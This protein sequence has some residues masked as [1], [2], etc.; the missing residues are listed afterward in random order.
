MLLL[1]V[2]ATA[3]LVGVMRGGRLG[4]LGEHPWR[5]RFLPFLAVSLQI[6]AFLPDESASLGTRTFAAWLHGASYG[7]VLAFVWANLRAPWMWLIGCGLVAN[8]IVIFANGGFMPVQPG[9]PG[10][11]NAE[12]AVKGLYNNVALVSQHTRFWLLGD[13]FETPGWVP[14]RGAFSIGDLAIGVGGF[15]LVQRLMRTPPAGD[16]GGAD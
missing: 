7:L 8:A 2:L 9:A 13:I 12:A 6:V 10:F 5:A 15:A 4:V 11:A 14:L 3:V 16:H 1:S